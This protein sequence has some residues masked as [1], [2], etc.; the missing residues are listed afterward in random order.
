[1]KI[2]V[3]LQSALIYLVFFIFIEP[4]LLYHY[5]IHYVYKACQ[6]IIFLYAFSLLISRREK[7]FNKFVLGVIIFCLFNF[8][9]TAIFNFKYIVKFQYEVL[10]LI[11][12]VI[13]V[14]YFAN[15]NLKNLVFKISNILSVYSLINV[16]TYFLY[17][18][19]GI[20]TIKRIGGTYINYYF[21]GMDNQFAKFIIPTII[22]IMLKN[23]LKKEKINFYDILIIF[24]N[25]LVIMI[26]W[27]VTAIISYFTLLFLSF[28][29]KKISLSKFKLIY[30]YLFI[31]SFVVLIQNINISFIN[32]VIMN[33]LKKTL[34]FSGRTQI[35]FEA[36]RKIIKSPIFGY[37]TVEGRTMILL[38]SGLNLSTHNI[39]LQTLIESGIVGF[40]FFSFLF[41]IAL[42]NKSLDND[43][44]VIRGYI[45]VF[46]IMM[47]M[48]MEVYQIDFLIL[49]L[50][51]IYIYKKNKI[52]YLK[53]KTL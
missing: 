30:I 15:I 47:T 7:T 34:T 45:G 31:F 4:P 43:K 6:Y 33:I 14:S 8:S 21:L 48:L 28:I 25:G 50:L 19:L 42:K 41:Y 16:I 36:I 9:I 20:L 29:C 35:W 49:I 38:R 32:N 12:F 3:N 46:S 44:F 53:G 1:M 24:L 5:K 22:L 37:G 23:S 26:S 13:C 17:Y 10:Y 52:H 39:I 18:P 51:L 2:R 40:F 11:S 27:S